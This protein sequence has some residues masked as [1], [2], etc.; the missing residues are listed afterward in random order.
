MDAETKTDIKQEERNK[1]KR[2]RISKTKKHT[3][4]KQNYRKAT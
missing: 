1:G 2:I 4:K 3:Q